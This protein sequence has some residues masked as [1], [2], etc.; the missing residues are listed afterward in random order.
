[1]L[2]II[3]LGKNSNFLFKYKRFF[4]S[5]FIGLKIF[6]YDAIY[7]F[8]YLYDCFLSIKIHLFQSF[9]FVYIVC[10]VDESYLIYKQYTAISKLNDDDTQTDWT[11]IMKHSL[12]LLYAIK[13][14]ALLVIPR[15]NK[16]ERIQICISIFAVSFKAD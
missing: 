10:N 14:M 8:F 2:N 6:S 1:M 5:A 4:A 12:R 11:E 3:N 9:P 7:V 16:V 13:I 15:Y